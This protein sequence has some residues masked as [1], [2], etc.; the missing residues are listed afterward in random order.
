MT[1]DEARSWIGDRF[2]GE[3]CDRVGRFLDIV[4]EEAMLQ[5]L[6]SPKTI[7]QIWLRHAL[8]SAQLLPLAPPAWRT[9]LDIGTG[10]G[11]PGMVVALLVP[12][13]QVT[14]VEP[15]RRRAEFLQRCLNLLGGDR[16][17][18][19]ADRAENLTI[20]ADV[21][22][23]RA[24]APTENLLRAAGQC[25]KAHTTW[26]LPRGQSGRAEAS[27]LMTLK[28]MMFHV[29]QSLT[30]SNSIILVGSPAR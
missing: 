29:E 3:A 6:I 13:R 21:I 19:V 17:F 22:S 26:L 1:E 14:M 23:A 25:A 10:A 7:P 15:R 8:D 4:L 20:K 24:V 2:G 16:A 18:V 11:F 9:W 5:N 28:G 12:D 30:D 27:A